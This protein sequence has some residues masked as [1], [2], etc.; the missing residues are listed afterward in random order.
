MGL[1]IAGPFAS[2]LIFDFLLAYILGIAFQYFTI[3]PMRGLAFAAGLKA[4]ARADTISIL[5]FEIGMFGWMAL[6]HFVFFPSPHLGPSQPL[7][8]FMMQIAMIVGVL[9]AYPANA[10]LIRKGWKEEMPQHE[11]GSQSR[12][13][14]KA[15]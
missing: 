12:G 13:T 15:A 1:T 8:W 2:R 7:F 9:T 11:R 4:A 6:T 10:W 5:L 3:V 14:L